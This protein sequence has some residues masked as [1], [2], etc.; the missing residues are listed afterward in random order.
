VNLSSR[1]NAYLDARIKGLAPPDYE[2]N[3]I[4]VAILEVADKF[5]EQPFW[6]SMRISKYQ[7]QLLRW[8]IPL[9]L[10]LLL[11]LFIGIRVIKN[12]NN[13]DKPIVDITTDAIQNIGLDKEKEIYV[14]LKNSKE[15]YLLFFKQAEFDLDKYLHAPT[16]W[17]VDYLIN[18]LVLDQGL[19]HSLVEK[20]GNIHIKEWD[21][22]VNYD[23]NNKPNKSQKLSETI[24]AN[25]DVIS[26]DVTF[27]KMEE[28]E[29]TA[30]NELEEI[31]DTDNQT[32]NV[33]V[34]VDTVAKVER[35]YRLPIDKIPSLK[36]NQQIKSTNEIL[37]L[38]DSNTWK[39]LRATIKKKQ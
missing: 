38:R 27:S 26:L 5:G 15:H 14:N 13:P 29:A 3:S 33:L 39:D 31:S 28:L 11:G 2:L 25:K 18:Y 19:T 32:K 36:S 17:T 30:M 8:L 22:L 21:L 9:G 16:S 10:T 12:R 35:K 23:F 34:I 6:N 1:Y 20:Y 4:N 24:I 37:R 7:G